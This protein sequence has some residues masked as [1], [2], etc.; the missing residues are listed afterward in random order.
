[1]LVEDLAIGWDGEAPLLEQANFGISRGSC[2]VILGPSGC[3]KTTLLRHLIGLERPR[4]GRIR[5]AGID[6]PASWR[7]RPGFGVLYQSAAL[8]GSL[9][10]AENCA[11]PLR[12]W[13]DLPTPV[14]SDL[15]QAKLDLVNLGPFADHRPDAV[16]G[17]MRKRAGI[18]RAM[19][20][21]PDLLFL[22]EPSAGLD[23]V[24]AADLD[25]LIRMLVEDLG[26]TAVV[27]TH[28]L[29]SIFRIADDCIMLDRDRRHIIARGNPHRLR[30]EH[31]DPAVHA[32]FNRL[33]SRPESIL[34]SGVFEV[35]R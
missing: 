9:T 14:I 32:F 1:V 33:P 21:E 12:A 27:V 31:R 26:I 5:I 7:G 34:G 11:L 29:A 2:F 15:V 24:T 17:G 10:L 23:P 4:A 8:F 3:G 6:D 16:S 19:V 25:L 20:L 28:E 35:P 18:A 13:T 22:D 30:D